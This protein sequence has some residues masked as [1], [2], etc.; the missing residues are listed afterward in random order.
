[1]T[2]STETDIKACVFD[3]YGTLFD[4]HSA[5]GK[6]Q[7]RF[8]DVAS[9]VSALWR[10]KQLEYTWL[11]SLMGDYADFWQVTGE[12]LEYALDAHEI[13]DSTLQDDLM[14][15]YLKLT[16]YSEVPGV[17]QALQAAGYKTAILSNGEPKMLGA[18]VEGSG[19]NNLL[20]ECLSVDTLRIF[21][22]DPS[23]YRLATDAF[24]IE[25]QQVLFQS[26]NAWDAAG[27]AH[28][29]FRVLWVNRF[30]QRPERLPAKPQYEAQ[31]L[32]HLLTVLGI[33][34]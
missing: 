22:P 7:H 14:Q 25:P 34:G 8:G 18:A 4:V 32:N 9:S 21:K 27:A 2:D 5:V 10:T 24:G 19:L 26:S 31:D 15:A 20:D 6:H 13:N 33:G 1:M 17:L 28:F 29:G 23:V 3:A 16:A 12:A 30:G 11:R